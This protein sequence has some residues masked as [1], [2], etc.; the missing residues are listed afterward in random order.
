MVYLVTMAYQC[1]LICCTHQCHVSYLYQVC[2]CAMQSYIFQ[3][4]KTIETI[5]QQ[6]FK[7]SH[8]RIKIL[9]QF[10]KEKS[11][12]NKTMHVTATSITKTYHTSLYQ[13]QTLE[14]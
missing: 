13:I 1:Q 2:N 4:K 12:I 10:L 11:E 5:N 3:L 8:L 9:L 14:A 7:N 6:K